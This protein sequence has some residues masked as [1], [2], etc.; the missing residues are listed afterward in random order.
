ME[1]E[2]LYKV[3]GITDEEK[4][5]TGEA[6]NKV[7]SKKFK[8]LALKYHPDKYATKPES[9]R[10]A[11][12]EQFKKISYAN[13]VLS[14][15]KKRQEY[16]NPFGSMG[17]GDFRGGHWSTGSAFHEF[18][19]DFHM[20]GFEDMEFMFTG[21]RSSEPPKPVRGEDIVV[22][23]TVT[24]DE[25]YNGVEKVLKYKRDM[26]CKACGGTGGEHV[27][28]PECHGSGSVVQIVGGI[29]NIFP[30]RRCGGTGHILSKEC[31][32][33][34]GEG[35][36]ASPYEVHMKLRQTMRNG[37]K[38]VFRGKGNESPM[39]GGEAGDM[40]VELTIANHPVYQVN[41]Q[42]DLICNV[43]VPVST[44]LVGGTVEIRHLDGKTL[45]VTVP[46]LRKPGDTL[47][48][49]GIGMENKYGSKGDLVCVI[50]Y[51]LPSSLSTEARESITNLKNKQLL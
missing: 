21:R 24:L 13:D 1:K 41:E 18:M 27:Q 32:V 35:R 30:C 6:F 28:C 36:V 10:K 48:L 44:A 23:L 12:E 31:P 16:D 29:H 14:D 19:R 17:G 4:K 20:P 8:K 9:E 42:G 33:C 40:Y 43:S 51:N 2:D 39:S 26:F 38:F 34:H 45:K 37:S 22:R 5:L 11:A 49:H 7:L 25:V 50:N 46:E 15:P 3:L 47:R